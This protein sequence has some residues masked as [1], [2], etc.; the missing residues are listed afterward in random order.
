MNT[1]IILDIVIKIKDAKTCLEKCRKRLQRV[2]VD[3]K[4]CA[5]NS[6]TRWWRGGHT[7][8]A[9]SRAEVKAR[10]VCSPIS[11]TAHPFPHNPR[12]QWAWTST[13]PRRTLPRL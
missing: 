2:G 4:V 10:F 7:I 11:S 13:R 1:Y 3:S 6:Q 12:S 9:E 8:E 5:E